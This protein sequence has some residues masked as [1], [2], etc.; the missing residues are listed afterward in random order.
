MRHAANWSGGAGAA[1]SGNSRPLGLHL[2]APG[3]PGLSESRDRNGTLSRSFFPSHPLDATD[4]ARGVRHSRA[5]VVEA[6]FQVPAAKEVVG[7]D[8]GGK[9]KGAS[10]NLDSASGAIRV[11]CLKLCD[12]LVV[13]EFESVEG[14]A[15]ADA[16]DVAGPQFR[17][18]EFS[19][20]GRGVL[21]QT[22]YPIYDKSHERR[23]AQLRL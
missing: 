1:Y 10:H 3:D 22:A 20:L 11:V 2:T 15:R 19:R 5:V 12:P 14:I 4:R 21:L 18:V 6:K 16:K 9:S 23:N 13:S 17:Q 7:A 8:R